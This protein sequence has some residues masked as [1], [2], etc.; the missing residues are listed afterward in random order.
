MKELTD[1]EKAVIEQMTGTTYDY[2][3]DVEED[4]LEELR[5]V[6]SCSC[7]A[8]GGFTGFI[9]YSETVDFFN[10]NGDLILDFAKEECKNLYGN[11]DIFLMFNGFNCLKDLS[12]TDIVDGIYVSGSDYETTVKNGLA[13][14][15]LEEVAYYL[16]E[17]ITSELERREE[18]EI[19]EE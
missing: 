15:A 11:D 10:R 1:L 3:E 7:G 13:W 4:T 9:Y 18:K 6:S 19:T 2:L 12:I 5:N 8:A 16:E 14:Y 17:D